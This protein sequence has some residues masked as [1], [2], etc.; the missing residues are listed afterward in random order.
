MNIN[1]QNYEIMTDNEELELDKYENRK[2]KNIKRYNLVE[3]FLFRDIISDK[4]D[5][6][7]IET[8]KP[9][10]EKTV[11][12]PDQ[13]FEGASDGY[14]IIIYTKNEYRL[15]YRGLPHDCW[16][17]DSHTKYYWTEEL[18]PYENFC[19]ATS[20]DGIN[21]N[22]KT[23]L[24]KN[25]FCHNFFP[26]YL[27]KEEKY[28]GISGTHILASGLF[29]FLSDDGINWNQTKKI[30][31]ESNILLN[32]Q[33]SNHFDSLNI[34]AYDKLTSIY[35]IYYRH[36]NINKRLVQYT[37]TTDFNKFTKCKLVNMN[38][39]DLEIYSPNIFNYFNSNYLISIPVI[40][41][42]DD[43]IKNCN[44]LLISKD[45]IN[46]NI[47]DNNLFDNN[48][49]MMSVHGIVS[50]IDKK[51]MYIYIQLNPTE[52]NQQID[53]Y[54]Y[55]MHRINKIT[56]NEI[57]YIKTNMIYLLTKNMSLNFETFDNGYI[58][59]EIYNDIELI[60]KSKKLIGNEFNFNIHWIFEDIFIE[61]NY[62][63]KFIL[64]KACL[65]SFTYN[66]K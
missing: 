20:N 60:L 27:E 30:I 42:P 35:Y 2:R 55:Q 3:P 63:I 23:S 57:G 5:N 29:L 36:N 43:F 59:I 49:N 14:Y 18:Y 58:I 15:Y 28:I 13:P 56:C 38:N 44:K 47:I 32:I 17:D 8:N 33:H 10:F 26:Y 16:H 39:N 22:K 11:L 48:I 6:I 66:I 64:N 4:S 34:I 37:K 51:K 45:N 21:F 41:G 25:N 19:L 50:S 7:I 12:K 24:F 54:S 46:F 62:Y 53:C 9:I 1:N 31:D 61:N 65:Y 52:K 40:K